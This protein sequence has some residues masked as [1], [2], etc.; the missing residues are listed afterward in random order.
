MVEKKRPNPFVKKDPGNIIRSGDWNEAQIMAREEIR[1]HTHTGSE[2]GAQIPRAGI[3]AAAIDGS[4]IDPDLSINNLTTNGTLSIKGTAMLGDIA[5]LLQ[6]IHAMDTKIQSYESK[7]QELND[8]KLDNN[9]D[10]IF[11]GKLSI[12]KDLTVS[13]NVGIGILNPNASLEVNGNILANQI[14]ANRLLMGF[15]TCDGR[16]DFIGNNGLDQTN[17]G[18]YALLQGADGNTF[19]NAPNNLC[20]RIGNGDRMIFHKPYGEFPVYN[21][22]FQDT[23]MHHNLYVYG[24]FGVS[25]PQTV[26]GDLLVNGKIISQNV[27]ISATIQELLTKVRN[28]PFL[29]DLDLKKNLLPLDNSLDRLMSLHGVSFSWKD[30][31]MGTD[32]E[33]GVIAQEVETVFPELVSRHNQNKAVKYHGLIPVLIEAVKE[34]KNGLDE[35][36]KSIQT[37]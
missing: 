9:K 13:G 18:N 33:I 1:A 22:I 11:S 35:V 20:L 31:S 4:L 32:R 21:E 3:E 34:L 26:G 7:I 23:I 36:R 28:N 14:T 24:S 6:K 25:G 5:D 12:E 19:L 8:F 17:P 10:S 37:K 30:E 16:Y 2:D 27:D 29:S 15:W